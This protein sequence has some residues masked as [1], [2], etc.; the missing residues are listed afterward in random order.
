MSVSDTDFGSKR[1]HDR[2]R[3][4]LK[5]RMHHPR[6]GE[7]DILVRDV[8]ETGLGGRCD[9]DLAVGEVVVVV[10]V[11]CEPAQGRIAW[12]KGQSF[13]LHLE[14]AINPA[15]VKSPAN[16]ERSVEAGYQVP[17][18][19]RPSVETKRPGFR[20]VRPSRNPPR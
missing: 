20:T 13:G 10:L 16:A 7:V 5:A 12:R 18:L 6:H 8:S 19:F 4:L 15:A 17:T 14:T 1:L 11:D 9:L 2:Q 3:R